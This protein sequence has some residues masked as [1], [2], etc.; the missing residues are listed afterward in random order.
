MD[1]K[2]MNGRMDGWKNEGWM[3][4]NIELKG[5]MSVYPSGQ[6]GQW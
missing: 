5:A 3:E 6:K 2:I 1:G 4:G